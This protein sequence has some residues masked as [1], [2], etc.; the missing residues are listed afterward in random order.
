MIFA[1]VKRILNARGTYVLILFLFLS[2]FMIGAY[3][4]SD[5]LFTSGEA[6]LVATSHE[7]YGG[8]TG[9]GS[10]S[11]EDPYT[12]PPSSPDPEPEEDPNEPPSEEESTT[13]TDAAGNEIETDPDEAEIYPEDEYYT[14]E[15]G[16]TIH[17]QPTSVGASGESP[18]DRPGET[19]DD[20]IEYPYSTSTDEY[21]DGA[22]YDEAGNYIGTGEGRDSPDFILN[23][24]GTYTGDDGTVYTKE[25]V[26]E[27]MKEVLNEVITEVREPVDKKK[28]LDEEPLWHEPE[29][30]IA[31]DRVVDKEP[32]PPSAPSSDDLDDLFGDIEESEDDVN[33]LQF[34]LGDEELDGFTEADRVWKLRS[35]GGRIDEVSGSSAF[36]DLLSFADFNEVTIDRDLDDLRFDYE[37]DD[38]V[39]LEAIDI[40]KEEILSEKSLFEKR[41]DP[42]LRFDSDNDGISDYD[43]VVLYKTN[44]F[45]D[46]TSDSERSD[47]EKI[48]AGINPVTDDPIIFEDPRDSFEPEVEEYSV[49]S[50]RVLETEVDETTGEETAKKLAFSGRA[51]P[52]SFV[53]LYIF[54]TPVV[55]TVK[56]DGNGRWEYELDRELEDG[57]HEIY[58]ATVDN[59]GKIVAKSEGV[60]FVK[61]ANAAEL[62]TTLATPQESGSFL[63]SNLFLIILGVSILAVVIMIII[64]GSDLRRTRPQE[65]HFEGDDAGENTT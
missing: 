29:E 52:D 13:T 11:N 62:G 20:L 7:G 16:N 33:D 46:S 15:Y 2:V 30:P 48:L 26:E 32:V 58:V 60:P 65:M 27:E 12:S 10:G 28:K 14:D 64:V 38:E 18:E 39:I 53:T 22:L 51:L 43:E 37:E 47:A 59:S 45:N 25:E 31:S 19:D 55:V 24:D 44:P 41:D 34:S 56:T 23:A 63:R 61:V 42:N 57:N 5:V 17:I 21:S 36:D 3:N 50:V 1:L 49:E 40:L 6:K 9:S 54:S 8:T 4:A 35:D